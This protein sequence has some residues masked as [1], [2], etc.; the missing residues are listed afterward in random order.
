MEETYRSN[1]RSFALPLIVT[2]MVVG[3]AL[4]FAFS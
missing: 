4:D 1:W 3:S 2:A